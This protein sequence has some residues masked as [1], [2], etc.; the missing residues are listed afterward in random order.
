MR[1][2]QSVVEI[3]G[4]RKK[5]LGPRIDY[6]KVTMRVEPSG[7]FEVVDLVDEQDGSRRFGFPDKFVSGLLDAL[8]VSRSEPDLALRVILTSADHHPIDSSPQ[9]FVEAGR[10]AGRK[11]AEMLGRS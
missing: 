2:L 9:A 11:L 1:P 5:H 3:I 4:T 7:V 6:A 8:G 10:D